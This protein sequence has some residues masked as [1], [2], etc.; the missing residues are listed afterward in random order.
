MP[1]LGKY[2]SVT[3]PMVFEFLGHFAR[4]FVL[5][6]GF[7]AIYTSSSL[8]PTGQYWARVLRDTTDGSPSQDELISRT[9]FQY[10]QIRFAPSGWCIMAWETGTADYPAGI[11]F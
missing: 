3:A 9:R 6:D 11:A 2:A 4:N 10:R 8:R 1:S 7:L 5:A